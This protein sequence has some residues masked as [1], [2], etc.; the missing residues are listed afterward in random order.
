MIFKIVLVLGY[1]YY[2]F[3]DD[4]VATDEPIIQTTSGKVR[5]LNI[6]VLNKGIDQFR[7]ILFFLIICCHL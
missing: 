3:G 6:N 2:V 4:F 7:K 5:G 1:F